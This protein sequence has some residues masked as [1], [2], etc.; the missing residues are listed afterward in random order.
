M[1]PRIGLSKM[2][3]WIIVSINTTTSYKIWI[4]PRYFTFKPPYNFTFF[5]KIALVPLA[6][7]KFLYFSG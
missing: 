4:T 7:I 5:E 2:N 3:V 6:M 1:F